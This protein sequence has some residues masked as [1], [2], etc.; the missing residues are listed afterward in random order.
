MFNVLRNSDT[1][2]ELAHLGVRLLL[3]RRVEEVTDVTN[4]N[5][6]V[7]DTTIEADIEKIINKVRRQDGLL[8]LIPLFISGTQHISKELFSHTDGYIDTNNLD[9]SNAT[10]IAINKRLAQITTRPS[11]D[12]ETQMH[13]K[14]LAF[15]HSRNQVFSPFAS[16]ASRIGYHFPFL[17]LY[18]NKDAKSL[19]TT[20]DVLESKGVI[21]KTFKDHIHLCK[22]CDSTYLNFKEICPSCKSADIRARDMIHHFVCAHVA[23]E[24]D[25]KTNTGLSCPKCDKNLRH[26]GIDYDKPSS[27]F[28]CNSCAH[29]FQN[30]EM[31]AACFDCETENALSELLQKVIGN[32][33][34]T[35]QGEQWLFNDTIVST[36]QSNSNDNTEKGLP[37]SIFK[38]VVKQEI[39]RVTANKVQSVFGNITFL[40]PQLEALNEDLKKALQI[41]ISEII[42]SYFTDS[43]LLCVTQYNNYYFLLTDTSIDNIT[44]LENI[45]YN[46][47]KLL[48]DNL[49]NESSPITVDYKTLEIEDTIDKLI[50]N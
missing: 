28:S 49:D 15:L 39:K 29:E 41:E 47:A 7:I 32:Y 2:R 40:K 8:C 31:Q 4:Y 25:F 27:I 3:V 17:S 43:D 46:L 5:G 10:I 38:I 35:P 33:S 30:P 14:T 37:L 21:A 44:R 34:I 18:F 20:L 1:A 13:Y 36:P 22:S 24:D 26:I 42:T 19:L 50:K 16:R 48:N 9:K 45:E 23:P 6:I 12:F 11:T